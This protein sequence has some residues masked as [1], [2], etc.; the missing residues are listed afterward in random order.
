M[1]ELDAY[2]FVYE[3]TYPTVESRSAY[4]YVNE[5][6]Y[7]VIDSRKAFAHVY[8]TVISSSSFPT[9]VRTAFEYAYEWGLLAPPATS[10]DAFEYA[11]E[12]S[13][14][15]P[16][17]PSRDAYEY[18]FESSITQTN[19]AKIWVYESTGWVQKQFFLWT[20][21]TWQAVT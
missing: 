4:A 9:T 19:P 21:S 13:L 15:A 10:R 18:A 2:A 8:E 14:I 20:G 12:W 17:A 7:P 3:N 6:V 11:Y 16:A 1:S 5:D